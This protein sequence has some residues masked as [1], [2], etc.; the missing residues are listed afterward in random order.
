MYV[1]LCH[2]WGTFL[3]LPLKMCDVAYECPMS[4]QKDST[5]AGGHKANNMKA[6]TEIC[7]ELA[8][9]IFSKR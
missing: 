1:L 9:I 7:L 5:I 6:L 2:D 3:P 8:K 4:T